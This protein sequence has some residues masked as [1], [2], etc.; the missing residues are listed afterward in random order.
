MPVDDAVSVVEDLPPD[1]QASV[2]EVV[3]QPDL[4]EVQEHLTY[5]DEARPK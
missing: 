4:E 1:L 3:E 5:A 2:M